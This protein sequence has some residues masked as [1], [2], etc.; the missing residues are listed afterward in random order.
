LVPLS[1][2]IDWGFL[3]GCFRSACRVGPEQP[4]LPTRLVDGL[5]IVKRMH[6]LSEE[7][8]RDRCVENPYSTSA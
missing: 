1:G 2:E 8:L 6:N 5:F 7:A 4:P 3:A